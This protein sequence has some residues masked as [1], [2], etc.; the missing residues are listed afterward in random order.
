MIDNQYIQKG[1]RAGALFAAIVLACG[2]A[3]AQEKLVVTSFGG[4]FEKLHRKNVIEP[5]EKKYNVQVQVVTSYSADA[6]ASLRAQKAAPQIDVVHFSAGHEAIAAREGLLTP[7]TAD[8]VPNIKNLYA[9][10]ATGLARGE[11]PVMLVA[12]VGLLYNKDKMERPTKWSDLWSGKAPDNRVLVDIATNGYGLLSFLM[13][14]K[15]SG[16]D[17]NNIEPG[18]KTVEQILDKATLVSTTPEL[19]ASVAQGN[20]WLSAFS[21]DYIYVMSKAGLPVDFVKPE[22]GTAGSFLTANLVAGR[23]NQDLARK[24]IDFELSKEVQEMWAREMRYSPSNKTVQLD[25]NLAK[26]LVYGDEEVAKL[27][28][29]EP[30]GIAE[31]LPRWV[32]DWKRRVTKS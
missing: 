19:Q 7:M 20:C 9:F 2:S 21:Q 3:A 22:E 27:V 12:A 18:L 26:L 14:N 13:I 29:F 15:V 5:F 8:E 11:G 16:G 4:E 6:L 25:P 31:N 23:P 10:G 32:E 24:F 30:L 1:L 17:L 28:R